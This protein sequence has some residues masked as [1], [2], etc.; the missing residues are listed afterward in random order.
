MQEVVLDR[1][2]RLLD[3]PGVVFNDGSAMLGNCVD[4]DSVEDP[5]PAVEA[6]LLRCNPASLVMTYNIPAFPPGN[7]MMFLAMVAKSYGRVLKGGVPD[8]IAAARAVLRDWNSGKI[9]YYTP[10]P[11]D[12]PL[13][14]HNDALIVSQ[15]AK[16][17]DISK[18]DDALMKTLNDKDEM[19]F[20]ALDQGAEAPCEETSENAQEVLDFLSGNNDDD[21]EDED[22]EDEDMEEDDDDDDDDNEG[23]KAPHMARKALAAAEDYDFDEM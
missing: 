23:A 16:A 1:N 19:D 10:A 15:F 21:D 6:L 14:T 22:D 11:K 13:T 8:K 17:F 18:Y 3:S 5:I 20:V 4:A 12:V 7:V 2:V 9:P